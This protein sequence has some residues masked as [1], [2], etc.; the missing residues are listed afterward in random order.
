MKCKGTQGEWSVDNEFRKPKVITDISKDHICEINQVWTDRTK[1][2]GTESSV[3]QSHNTMMATA[4]LISA[5]PELLEALESLLP[6]VPNAL[7]EK[8][9]YQ[10][11]L[12]A[13]NKALK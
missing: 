10:R 3:G 2:D 12:K 4:K 9:V 13:I 6:L 7:R 1:N 8:K 5:A 11:C